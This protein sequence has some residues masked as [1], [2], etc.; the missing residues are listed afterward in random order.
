MRHLSSLNPVLGGMLEP[1]Y[2]SQRV[3]STANMVQETQGGKGA[4]ART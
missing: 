2:P 1:K 3:Y 4:M